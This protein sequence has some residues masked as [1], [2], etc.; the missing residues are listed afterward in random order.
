MTMV[1]ESRDIETGCHIQRTKEYV[2]LLANQL[3][4]QGLFP[5]QLSPM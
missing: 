2:R 5:R 1:A 3:L 4:C